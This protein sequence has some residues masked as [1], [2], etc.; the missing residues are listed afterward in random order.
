MKCEQCGFEQSS[1]R[2][3]DNCG[4]SLT[5]IRL[6]PEEF[7]QLNPQAAPPPPAAAGGV[8]VGTPVLKCLYCGNEQAS[9]KFCDAC[10]MAFGTLRR[11]LEVEAVSTEVQ[12]RCPTCGLTGSGPVCRN[13]GIRIPGSSSEE[14]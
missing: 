9:G 2:F 1:G 12:L 7:A 11:D 3:C 5:R 6:T 4:R 10:G 14:T 13:C 8:V